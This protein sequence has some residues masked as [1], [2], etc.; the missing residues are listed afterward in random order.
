MRVLL[1][2]TLLVGCAAPLL[3]QDT[4]PE[5]VRIRG[6]YETGARA[7]FVVLPASG[8]DSVRAIVQ[9]DLDFSDRFE[10]I[11]VGAGAPG[12]SI[13]YR[14]YRS[15]GA[16]YGL[17][18]VTA[19]G[20][21][22]VR[23][24]DVAN[25]RIRQTQT[26]PLP[27]EGSAGFRLAVHALADEVVRWVTGTPGIAATRLLFLGGDGRV[28]RVDSDGED[29][30]PITP[31][32]EKAFSPAWAPDGR[33]IAYTRFD[34][35]AIV[36]RDLAAGGVATVPGTERGMNY[37]A[38]FAPDGR[39]LA[40][41]RTADGNTDIYSANVAERCCV[42]RLTVGRFSDNL[43]PTYAPDGR[44]LAFVSTR[45]GPPQIYAMDRDGTG[46]DVLAPFDYG[47]TGASNAPEWSPDGASVVFHRDVSRAPQIFVLDV[48][49]RR[50]RQATSSGRNEDPTWA[51]DGR[52][53]AFVSDRSGRRQIWIMD[54]ETGRVRQ[55]RTP[56]IVRLPSWSR[57]LRATGVTNP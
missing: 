53:V 57:R 21:V 16:S 48:A 56:G 5:G 55:V 7:G 23:L 6:Q 37:A 45:S 18:M 29:A 50:V 43:S 14:L 52:H 46:Q 54:L 44:R 39:T 42:Q 49:T 32:G 28:W 11:T 13:N 47:E 19:P 51:P 12:S 15:L 30:T 9:R 17:E 36:V 8:L 1:A 26:V 2:A 34:T 25:G 41:T 20:G 35:G 4:T 33:R 3:A 27:P 40:Y 38:A 10:L 31:A 24:H 22:T